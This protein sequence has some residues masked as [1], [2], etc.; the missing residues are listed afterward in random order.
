M[1]QIQIN[2]L[3]KHTHTH[4]MRLSV[5][6]DYHRNDAKTKL[7]NTRHRLF[8]GQMTLIVIKSFLRVL[9]KLTAQ[10]V[11][12]SAQNHLPSWY[13]H[14]RDNS[15]ETGLC[16]QIAIILKLLLK[17][18]LTISMYKFNQQLYYQPRWIII[19]IFIYDD[20]DHEAVAEAM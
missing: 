14:K 19:R 10:A 16:G 5:L 7:T 2:S 3:H 8:C 1:W 17:D 6:Q 13:N 4:S 11:G 15:T 12:I 20:H 9:F 18:K